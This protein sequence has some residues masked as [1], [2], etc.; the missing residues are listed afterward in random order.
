MESAANPASQEYVLNMVVNLPELHF[1]EFI[2]FSPFS[3]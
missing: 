2:Y 1:P 3:L